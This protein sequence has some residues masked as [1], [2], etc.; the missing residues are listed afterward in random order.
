LY[1]SA[2]RIGRRHADDQNE[3]VI[4]SR[5][6]PTPAAVLLPLHRGPAGELR[7]V[8]IE[9]TRHGR[10][11]GQIALP[12]GRHEPADADMRAT[13]LREACEEL[14]LDAEAVEVL[15]EL[16]SM[17]TRS[18]GFQVWPFV[19]RLRTLPAKWAPQEAEVAAVL[20]L[21]VADLVDPVNAGEQEMNFATWGLRRLVPVRRVDGHTIWGLTLR[22]LEA[23]LPRVLAGEFDV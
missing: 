1:A 2:G 10:H 3:G 4:F 19:G 5:S 11:G 17:R 8:M 7:L 23:A 15:G 12:G 13:A 20:D 9:R 14:G 21:A 22:I 6:T 16:A 18:T